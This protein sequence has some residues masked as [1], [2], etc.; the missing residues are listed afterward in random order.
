[1]K[2]SVSL[3][4]I[5]IRL[6]LGGAVDRSMSTLLREDCKSCGEIEKKTQSEDNRSVR[7]SYLTTPYFM[8]V[9]CVYFALFSR[10][11]DTSITALAGKT[12]TQAGL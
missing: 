2:G 11:S 10:A 12:I 7:L 5:R 3:N 6:R 9:K 8:R 4:D 1:M